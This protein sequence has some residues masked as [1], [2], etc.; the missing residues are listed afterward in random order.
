M[1]ILTFA[2]VGSVSA[3]SAE[4]TPEPANIPVSVNGYELTYDDIMQDSIQYHLPQD[5][6]SVRE[7]AV[8]FTM[9]V[10]EVEYPLFTMYV[11][12]DDGDTHTVL[13]SEA[14]DIIPVSFVM[15]PISEDLPEDAV[16]L[17]ELDAKEAVNILI[18]TL[19]V[20]QLPSGEAEIPPLDDVASIILADYQLT[21][22]T[23]NSVRLQIRQTGNQADF[24]LTLADAQEALAFTL[25]CG[26]D[27]GDAVV[28]VNDGADAMVPVAFTMHS[29]PDGLSD[30]DKLLFY[31]AQELVN[32]VM[33]TMMLTQI[34]G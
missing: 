19:K 20:H 10:Q 25:V 8:A 14:G 11:N 26:S 2:F 3:E 32:D 4:P 12:S 33:N 22:T 27:T 30:A 21:F 13:W 17:F 16:Q 24:V 31:Q 18:A 15:A 9:T 23:N 5:E 7:N 6:L 1:M 28:M 34:G 29:L